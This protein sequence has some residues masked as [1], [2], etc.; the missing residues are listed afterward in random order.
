MEKENKGWEDCR[1]KT[2]EL[3]HDEFRIEENIEMDRAHK[4][5]RKE[6][7]IEHENLF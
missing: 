4:T 5:G 6:T 3:F 2:N 7:N 1:M